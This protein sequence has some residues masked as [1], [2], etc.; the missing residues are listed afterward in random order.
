MGGSAP[1]Q[2][3]ADTLWSDIDCAAHRKRWHCYTHVCPL[4]VFGGSPTHSRADIDR[5]AIASDGIAEKK[6]GG[7][8]G[9]SPTL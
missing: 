7:R 8:L 3:V 5:A 1:N 4:V 2:P 6:G 9:G